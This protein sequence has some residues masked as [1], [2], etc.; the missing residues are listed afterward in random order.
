M[1]VTTGISELVTQQTLRGLFPIDK[2]KWTPV[3]V[4]HGRICNS[5]PS[6]GLRPAGFTYSFQET[7][8]GE[9]SG[10]LVGLVF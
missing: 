4:K 9:P 8:L 5:M 6:Y 3:F 2:K 7:V 10:G 1:T